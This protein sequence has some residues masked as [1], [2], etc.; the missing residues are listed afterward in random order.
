M[1]LIPAWP[2]LEQYGVGRLA[3]IHGNLDLI[4]LDLAGVVGDPDIGHDLLYACARCSGLG[5]GF[6]PARGF[7]GRKGR[8]VQRSTVHAAMIRLL[9]Q[10]SPLRGGYVG[11]LGLHQR[12]RRLGRGHTCGQA[13]RRK[14]QSPP[15]ERKNEI[16]QVGGPRGGV[17]VKAKSDLDLLDRAIGVVSVNPYGQRILEAGGPTHVLE[18]LGRDLHKVEARFLGQH[19]LL[20]ERYTRQGYR[21]QG[22]NHKY[23]KH[24]LLHGKEPPLP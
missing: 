3:G 20:G 11:V 23:G 4:F 10:V 8:G 21:H 12:H 18:R 1:H 13:G 17:G 9:K 16:L 19:R 15:V 7:A 6:V 24:Y 5:A 14:H 22:Q 2:W